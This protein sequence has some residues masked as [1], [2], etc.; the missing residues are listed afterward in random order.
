VRH[1]ILGHERDAFV[2]PDHR[3]QV[4]PHPGQ[5]FVDSSAS[6]DASAARTFFKVRVYP[7][8]S[9]GFKSIFASRAS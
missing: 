1:Q 2:R 4:R 3:F 7:R 9:S 5:T 8:V 6:S